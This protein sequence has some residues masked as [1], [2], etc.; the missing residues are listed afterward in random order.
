MNEVEINEI[1]AEV[2]KL[3]PDADFGEDAKDVLKLFRWELLKWPK[4]IVMDAMRTYRL[5]CKW[6]TP[7]LANVVNALEKNHPGAMRR[8]DP[9]SKEPPTDSLAEAIRK[10]HPWLSQ[11]AKGVAGDAEVLMRKY[12]QD[13][14]LYAASLNTRITA[15]ESQKAWAMKLAAGQQRKCI[16]SIAGG[17]TALGVDAA[18]ARQW[19]EFSV[20]AEADDF[21][22]MLED[23]R[24]NGIKTVP[25]EQRTPAQATPLI[26]IFSLLPE[27]A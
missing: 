10:T 20:S 9:D 13:W 1:M 8:P 26:P 19:A 23:I 24:L 7:E 18:E 15:D 4:A 5:H 22:R 16:T 12:R 21:K 6:K 25:E 11:V 3:W 17:L 14:V 2:G 27:A